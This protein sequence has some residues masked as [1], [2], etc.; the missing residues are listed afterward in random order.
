MTKLKEKLKFLL[1]T[2]LVFILIHTFFFV[3]SSQLNESKSYWTAAP[4]T[5]SFIR[6]DELDLF[7]Q[8][9]GSKDG[10]PIILIAGTAAWGDVWENNRIALVKSG[11][12][13]ITIDLPPFGFSQKPKNSSFSRTDQAKR[14]L[15]VIKKM[16]INSFVLVSHSISGRAA[17]EASFLH[18]EK[19]KGLVLI[20]TSS[21]IG[22]EK[23]ISP[24]LSS[25]IFSIKILRNI[26]MSIITN[27]L[28]T[29]LFLERIVFDPKSITKELIKI[30]RKPFKVYESNERLGDWLNKMAFS[31]DP[32]FSA[33]KEEYKKI[34]IPT[35]IVWGKEDTII[36]L[37]EGQMLHKNIK[38]S[39]LKIFEKTNHAP[40]LE[41][42]E[43]FNTLLINFLKSLKLK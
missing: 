39:K 35:L 7:V 40:H 2:L 31:P 23:P 22:L 6:V 9:F 11:Y 14:I 43:K 29:P 42:S 38:N 17:L 18:M 21:G 1:V 12:R 10:F 24:S 5:G 4:K 34:K 13:A 32:G 28:L 33:R 3:L 19:F 41:H 27:G 37:S 25:Q 20:S 30:F 8:D 16:N 26:M 36:P 15:A